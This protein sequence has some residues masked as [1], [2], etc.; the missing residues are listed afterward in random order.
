MLNTENANRFE[1]IVKELKA[2]GLNE[3]MAVPPKRIE[4][5]LCI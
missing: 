4:S 1:E 5:P 2:H 3:Y